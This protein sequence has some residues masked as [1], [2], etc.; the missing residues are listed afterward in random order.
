[1]PI[2]ADFAIVS[3]YGNFVTHLKVGIVSHHHIDD[4]HRV[5]RH[6]VLGCLAIFYLTRDIKLV[7]NRSRGYLEAECRTGM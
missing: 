2:V 5:T 1:M 3:K 6:K 4:G 7:E